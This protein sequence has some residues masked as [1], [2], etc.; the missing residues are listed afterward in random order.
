MGDLQ[1]QLEEAHSKVEAEA[2]AGAEKA[3]KAEYQGYW[4]RHE[5]HIEFFQEFLITL[6]PDSF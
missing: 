3:A 6:A 5:D 4:R 2:T 1:R